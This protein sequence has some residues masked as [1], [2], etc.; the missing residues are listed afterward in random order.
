MV[1]LD[2]AG[3]LAYGFLVV[4]HL[5]LAH[6]RRVGFLLRFGGSVGWL[7]L[8]VA[9]GLSSVWFWSAV[10]AAGDLYGWARWHPEPPG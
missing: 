5:A 1:A 9:L 2:A 8:G 7:V 6:R 3:H 4:G 10:F